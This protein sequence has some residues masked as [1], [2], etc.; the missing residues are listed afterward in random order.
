M[1][2]TAMQSAAITTVSLIAAFQLQRRCHEQL[3]FD[4]RDYNAAS[5]P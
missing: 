5:N 3:P 1:A 2:H 4:S